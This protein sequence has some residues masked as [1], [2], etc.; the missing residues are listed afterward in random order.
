[1]DKARKGWDNNN[2]HVLIEKEKKEEKDVVF[3]QRA[4]EFYELLLIKV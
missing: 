2:F 1:M 3:H 4:L